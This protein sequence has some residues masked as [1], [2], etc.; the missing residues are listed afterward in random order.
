[1]GIQTPHCY[2]AGVINL[3]FL[4][5]I[6]PFSLDILTGADDIEKKIESNIKEENEKENQIKKLR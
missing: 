3:F 6:G 1:M 5:Q 4:Y 2:I